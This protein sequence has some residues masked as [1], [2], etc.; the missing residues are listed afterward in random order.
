MRR[1]LPLL[2]LLAFPVFASGRAV[3]R[4]EYTFGVPF[5]FGI[6]CY[7]EQDLLSLDGLSFS[8]GAEVRGGNLPTS[9]T[10]YLGS[11]FYLGSYWLYLEPGYSLPLD[12]SVGEK[13][14]RVRMMFGYFW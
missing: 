8:L 6:L 9:L 13:V 12:G 4:A 1:V 11:T 14:L 5:P 3:C 2:L 7:A 10:L